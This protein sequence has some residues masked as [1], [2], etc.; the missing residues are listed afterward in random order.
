MRVVIRN[1]WGRGPE[2]G[3]VGDKSEG[4]ET[5]SPSLP[6]HRQEINALHTKH[7]SVTPFTISMNTCINLYYLKICKVQGNACW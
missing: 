4:Q 1:L 5:R 6:Q 7:Y 2:Q 3:A